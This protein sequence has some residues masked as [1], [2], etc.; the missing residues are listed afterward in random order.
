M[1]H[2][3]DLIPLSARLHR[4]QSRMTRICIFLAVF[5]VSVMFGMADMYLQGA[6]RRE[7]EENG[8]W[9]CAFSSIDSGTASLIAA[10]P[11]VR[12]SE[13]VHETEDIF[14]V[15]FSL[16]CPI[17]EVIAEIQEQ[18]QLSDEQVH[19]HTSLLSL[20]G[21]L[22]G[23]SMSRIY[24][25]SFFLSVLVVLTSVLMISSSLNSSV[26]QRTE[27][28]GLLRCLGAS[29]KQILRLVRK[30]ALYWC[31][32][33]IPA[34]LGLSILVVCLLSAAMRK[35][36][37]QWFSSMPVFGISFVSLA[38]GS[39][40]GLAAVLL[41]ARSPA[42]LASGVS[43]LEAASGNAHQAASF[44]HAANTRFFR[45]ET[46]LGV[47]HAAARKKSW[48]L[49]TGAFAVCVCLFLCFS[50]LVDFMENAMMPK[51]WT[52]ELSI[53]SDTNTCSISPELFQE[54]AQSD[55]V[56][57]V[58]G[59]MFAYNVPAMI[60]GKPCS[61]NLISQEENQFRWAEASLLAGSID[62][63]AEELNQMLIVSED[64]DLAGS[65]I[66]LSIDGKEHAVTVAGVLSDSPLARD[67]GTETIL[68]SEASFTA[69]TGEQGYTIL[70]IQFKNSASEED[71]SY[72]KSLFSGGV[73][74]TDSLNQI[75]QQ[76][77]LYRAFAVLVYGFLSII[78]AITVFHIMNTIR[79]G[80]ASQ[81]RQYGIM[82]AAGMSSRQLIKMIR[83]E[84]L[85]YAVSGI[86]LGCFLGIPMHWVVYVSLI[87]TF[88]GLSWSVPWPA[89]GFII[90]V[91]LFTSL[92]SC[93]GPA[94]RL[95]AM[96]ITEALRT[97]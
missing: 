73:V 6:T 46:A 52:P 57:R 87:T 92:L 72:I 8:D 17:T 16:F 20:Q 93:R 55:S 79:M 29:R 21:Q 48:L 95:R 10:R 7:I 28:F 24:E 2:Y 65:T 12:E 90:C 83:A 22:K 76:R 54:T 50:T 32:T 86:L 96:S 47:H 49:M 9:H 58:Y 59:R 25:I 85:T 5:L 26:S 61:S 81:T 74:F 78:T 23:T 94:R 40:L 44:R 71:V 14:V 91:I 19:I 11:E 30:E 15:R 56:K 4:R 77:N 43:P 70:D 89:L 62:A 45:I 35:I 3:L 37:P 63:A 42:R 18:N 1:K 27:F 51:A 36:S 68:C 82:R 66:I 13:W 41:A 33:A 84:A 53:A 31:R 60:D 38:A 88:W 39:L 80:A 97:Q 75:R 34:G 69:L 64:A 67:E